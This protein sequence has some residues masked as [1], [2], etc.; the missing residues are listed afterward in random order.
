MGRQR[1]PINRSGAW[2]F[3]QFKTGNKTDPDEL[4]CET[5][6]NY[7]STTRD[8]RFTILGEDKDTIR[9]QFTEADVGSSFCLEAVL[10][11][12]NNRS[13]YY[14]HIVEGDFINEPTTSHEIKK[15]SFEKIT[16][17]VKLVEFAQSFFGLQVFIIC[18]GSL[19]GVL[20][21]QLPQQ[22]NKQDSD[23]ID[24]TKFK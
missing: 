14:G 1:L 21:Y 11:S 20:A 13:I 24:I 9:I 16:K 15:Q 2:R 3:V 23:Q 19:I 17:P 6:A 12:E 7:G 18:L 4:N 5:R 8:D 10:K 22:K